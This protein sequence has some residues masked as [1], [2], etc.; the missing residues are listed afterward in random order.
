MSAEDVQ[1][2]GK[3]LGELMFFNPGP[4]LASA[5][6]SK[7]LRMRLLVCP[8]ASEHVQSDNSTSKAPYP[9]QIVGSFSMMLDPIEFSPS[10]NELT[11]IQKVAG[12]Y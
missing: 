3:H 2:H 11:E 9:N 12:D 7:S 1:S 5:Q 4:W 8:G 10:I 6:G